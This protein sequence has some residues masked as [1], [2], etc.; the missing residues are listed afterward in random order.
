MR[1]AE[2][3]RVVEGEQTASE[4]NELAIIRVYVEQSQVRLDG[5]TYQSATT[6]LYFSSILTFQH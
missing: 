4:I 2:W 5:F 3:Q 6:C 1:R